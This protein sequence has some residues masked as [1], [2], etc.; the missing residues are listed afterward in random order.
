MFRFVI[1]FSFS[2]LLIFCGCESAPAKRTTYLGVMK[3]TLQ[4][5]LSTDD[6]V[7]Q[8]IG[9]RVDWSANFNRVFNQAILGNL[10]IPYII[11]EPQFW[12]DAL[13]MSLESITNGEWDNYLLDWAD[14]LVDFEYP[15]MIA[16]APQVNNQ[17][18]PWSLTSIA[19]SGDDY[20]ASYRYIVD[21]FR[22]H[23]AHNVY[24]VWEVTSQP[25]PL[26]QW[27]RIDR[28]YPGDDY[29]DW[30][31]LFAKNWGT[32]HDWSQWQPLEL[33]V[34][35]MLRDIHFLY[36]KPIAL[37]VATVNQGGDYKQWIR[38][39]P[40]QLKSSLSVVD[41]VMVAEDFY[42]FVLDDDVFSAD[43]DDFQLVKASS[44]VT[45][46]VIVFDQKRE[47]VLPDFIQQGAYYWQGKSDF[48]VQL[49]YGYLDADSDRLQLSFWITDDELQNR[50][51]TDGD[52]VF[53]DSI[54]VLLNGNQWAFN[55]TN[56]EGVWD[57]AQHRF[58]EGAEINYE[59]SENGQF[60]VRLILPRIQSV[61]QLHFVFHDFDDTG[62]MR[63]K[64]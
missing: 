18:L 32:V 9:Y 29:V 14:A 64:F 62:Y 22:D 43:V 63:V 27:N 34:G 8:V 47:I 52:V 5:P 15:V 48:S 57:L 17:L 49:L 50:V 4:L 25:D 35:T 20:I 23:G 58:V 1:I 60:V 53:G 42:E 51:K 12:D 38:D 39:I 61:D 33:I 24:W 11:W 21:F 40:S 41:L 56:S 44:V 26:T 3:N 7:P 37:R 2:V 28:A 59:R 54:E 55:L 13:A 6:V 31:S 45:Q 46:N 19:Q 10:A 36:G 16:F 30:I